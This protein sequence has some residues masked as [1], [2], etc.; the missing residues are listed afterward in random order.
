MHMRPAGPNPDTVCTAMHIGHVA[1]HVTDADEYADFASCALGLSVVLRSETAILM[2]ASEKHHELELVRADRNGFGHIGL[3]VDSAEELAS[4]MASIEGTGIACR[5]LLASEIVGFG[6]GFRFT[7]PGGLAHEIYTGMTRDAASI[8]AYTRGHVR[9]FGHLTFASADHAAIEAFWTEVLG[10]RVSDRFGRVTWMRCDAE[11]HGLAVVPAVE[12]TKLHHQA[13]QTQDLS[14]MGAYC[15]A[16]IHAHLALIWGPVRHG[17]G[18][19]LATY[20]PDTAGAIIEVYADMLQIADDAGYKAQ[21][22]SNEPNAL[23]MWGPPTPADFMSFGLP[24]L[25]FAD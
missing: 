7:G 22:W 17:P 16:L 25:P 18:F 3:E 11:H 13:W 20:L 14:S 5:Q 24:V 2:S 6:E 10:F 23:N 15:D 21:D 12:G 8:R 4:L 9:R 19:N 1:L